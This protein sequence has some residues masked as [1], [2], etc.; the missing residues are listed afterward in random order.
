LWNI[1]IDCGIANADPFT[2]Y[3]AFMTTANDPSG[4]PMP[5]P[6]HLARTSSFRTAT[7]N[8]AEMERAMR[9]FT[10]SERKR[11]E[12][13]AVLPVVAVLTVATLAKLGAVGLFI[14]LAH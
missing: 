7:Y 9:I 8:A 3:F 2:I 12:L 6:T 10:Q 4:I 11:S 13:R 1:G 14:H 5:D